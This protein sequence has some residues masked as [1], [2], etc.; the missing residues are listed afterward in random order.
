MQ[1]VLVVLYGFSGANYFLCVSQV[2]KSVCILTT[3]AIMKL[4]KSKEATAAVDIKSWPTVMD[5]G[6]YKK[7]KHLS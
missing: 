7:K 2:S 4:L 5:T 1:L 6:K 3:Q